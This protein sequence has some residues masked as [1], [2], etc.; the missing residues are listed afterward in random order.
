[1]TLTDG[2]LDRQ[3]AAIA[4]YA[5]QASLNLGVWIT[6]G[7]PAGV[8][9]DTVVLEFPAEQAQAREI[10][11][12]PEYRGALEASLAAL[13]ENTRTFRTVLREPERGSTPAAGAKNAAGVPFYPSVNP[14]EARAALEEPRIAAVL[15]VFK[16]RIAEIRHA[17]GPASVEGV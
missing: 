3:W 17:P 9:G 8:E 16:G 6:Q 5:T 1:M 2:N 14:E 11:E 13:T 7:K 4:A 10:V 15:E 12:K